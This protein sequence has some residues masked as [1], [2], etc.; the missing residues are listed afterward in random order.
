M[1]VLLLVYAQSRLQSDRLPLRANMAHLRQ[2][3]TDPGLGFQVKVLDN[4]KVVPSS[5]GSGP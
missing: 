4:F 1:K 5:L 3:K 2:S